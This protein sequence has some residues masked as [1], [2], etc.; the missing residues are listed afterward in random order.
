M[1]QAR[2]SRTALRVAMRRAAHQLYDARPLVFDD[3]IAVEFLGPHA[4]ELNRTPGRD[5]AHK[6]RPFSVALRS[7]SPCAAPPTS[8]TTPDRW[9]S[10]TP[11][12]SP[13]WVRMPRNSTA[14]PAAIPR[15]SCARSPLP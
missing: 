14:P 13:S 6:L 3:P 15:T 4:Q 11:L 2:P 1:Q 9:S 7:V 8:S 5:P 12:P 10:T